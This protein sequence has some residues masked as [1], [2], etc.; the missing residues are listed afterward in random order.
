MALN[1]PLLPS[2]ES[3]SSHEPSC[4]DVLRSPGLWVVAGMDLKK[5]GGT[6]SLVVPAAR[7]LS[8]SRVC[9][10]SGIPISAAALACVIVSLVLDSCLVVCAFVLVYACSTGLAGEPPKRQYWMGLPLWAEP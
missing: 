3:L 2:G 6:T 4:G 5:R 10:R 9:S 1:R 8:Q 7:T